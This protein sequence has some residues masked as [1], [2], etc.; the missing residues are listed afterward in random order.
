MLTYNKVQ[1]CFDLHSFRYCF[2]GQYWIIWGRDS[3]TSQ[4]HNWISYPSQRVKGDESKD[5]KALEWT[6][7]LVLLDSWTHESKSPRGR[8]KESKS[9]ARQ[10][11]RLDIRGISGGHITVLSNSI[12]LVWLVNVEH[13]ENSLC[14]TV[15]HNLLIDHYHNMIHIMWIYC[16][17]FEQKQADGS[18]M[19]NPLNATPLRPGSTFIDGFSKLIPQ[20]IAVEISYLLVYCPWK[21]INKCGVGTQWRSV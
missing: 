5:F 1:S 18:V 9:L 12:Q 20:R 6:L 2:L 4:Y 8:V 14:H 15:Y 3:L 10:S 19:T 13:T 11:K 17:R 7:W 16:D 21:S